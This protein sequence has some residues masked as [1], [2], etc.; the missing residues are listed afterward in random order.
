MINDYENIIDLLYKYLDLLYRGETGFIE[1]VF[2]PEATVNSVNNNKIVS[3]DMTGFKERVAT[4]KSP[5]SVGEKREDKILM[6]DISSP[7][8]AIAKV[9]CMILGNQYTDYLSLLKVQGEWSII[10]KVFHM[11]TV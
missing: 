11:K 3:V 5:E 7:T 4:R 8:T 6:I 9:E 2:L 10:S 1:Q